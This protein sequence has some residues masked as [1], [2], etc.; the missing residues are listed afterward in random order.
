VCDRN[1]LLPLQNYWR[2]LDQLC[3]RNLIK[4]VNNERFKCVQVR[5][6]VD[7]E[8]YK[9]CKIAERK[10]WQAILICLPRVVPCALKQRKI[11]KIQQKLISFFPTN[12]TQRI[13]NWQPACSR[14]VNS[15]PDMIMA[16]DWPNLHVSVGGVAAVVFFIIKQPFQD[17]YLTCMTM[18]WIMLHDLTIL[19]K[20]KTTAFNKTSMTWINVSEQN[21]Y[22]LL[23]RSEQTNQHQ[24]WL[25]S[26]SCL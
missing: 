12:S 18:Q 13:S 17:S 14:F 15:H 1:A 16:N 23:F 24:S 5:D 4:N 11:K 8:A 25:T 6:K 22:E 10:C 3:S 20:L 19:A 26:L 7:S 21:I 9:R 2:C